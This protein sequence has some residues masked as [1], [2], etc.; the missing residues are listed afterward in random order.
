[1]MANGQD[2][3]Q[4]QAATAP[5]AP[6][7]WLN[8]PCVPA[9]TWHTAE[10]SPSVFEARLIIPPTAISAPF[11]S[12]TASTIV[13]G[14]T[15]STHQYQH[16]QHQEQQQHSHSPPVAQPVTPVQTPYGV[17]EYRPLQNS[18]ER[19]GYPTTTFL[20]LVSAPGVHG[21][22]NADRSEIGTNEQNCRLRAGTS[23]SVLQTNG[24]A[25]LQQS[26][27]TPMA[28]TAG[29]LP[30][31]SQE[32][33]SVSTAATESVADRGSVHNSMMANTTSRYME[34]DVHQSVH[35][36]NAARPEQ[37]HPSTVRYSGESHF[38]RTPHSENTASPGDGRKQVQFVNY[39]TVS[40]PFQI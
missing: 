22:N 27:V 11:P 29:G 5:T 35:G 36:M 31:P 37:G 38:S 7:T 9:K 6:A 23:V 33:S 26:D 2:G 34:N 3:L 40:T 14:S 10:A 4:P 1:M 12:P 19:R 30:W 28:S 18:P 8:V 24:S 16:Q 21:S 13:Q 20:R 15:H 32:M 39:S 25:V 17:S